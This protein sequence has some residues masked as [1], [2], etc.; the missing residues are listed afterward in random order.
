MKNKHNLLYCISCTSSF[1][2]YLNVFFINIHLVEA[3]SYE[4]KIKSFK[5]L[6][7]PVTEK[8]LVVKEVIPD[9]P[10]LIAKSEYLPKLITPES[11]SSLSYIYDNG[12]NR[13]YIRSQLH[14]GQYKN[15]SEL[16]DK[17]PSLKK[18]K[19]RLN[20]G[21]L[22]GSRPIVT[23]GLMTYRGL[24]RG[25]GAGFS[26]EG[27]FSLGQLQQVKNKVFAG[28]ISSFVLKNFIVGEYGIV[29]FYTNYSTNLID[30]EMA[31]IESYSDKAKHLIGS[32]ENISY[33]IYYN[34]NIVSSLSFGIE[35]TGFNQYVLTLFYGLK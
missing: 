8:P 22:M 14:F 3:Q 18:W 27:V 28:R 26:I 10:I 13:L 23:A 20:L 34:H 4:N 32:T 5:I 30:I 9:K 33:G 35:G 31:L 21:L 6:N 19:P 17:Y 12:L 25:V 16:L 29:T 1:L 15:F 11:L 2:I 7:K 24:G